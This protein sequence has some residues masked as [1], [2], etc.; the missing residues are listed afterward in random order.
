[1]MF[2]ITGYPFFL[3]SYLRNI[4]VLF[5][6]FLPPLRPES[7]D[8]SGKTVLVVGA[9]VGIGLEISRALASMGATVV[10]AC[11]NEGKAQSARKDI[12]ENSQGHILP[13]QV[14]VMVLDCEDLDSVRQFVKEWGKR[15]LDILIK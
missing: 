4:V 13:N 2:S 5:E 10:L 12:L 11:R 1:M 3:L 6:R 8:L 7:R 15:P 9:N 14:E